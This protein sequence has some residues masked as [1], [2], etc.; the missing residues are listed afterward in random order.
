MKVN[1]GMVSFKA[2]V[3]KVIAK[4]IV[5]DIDSNRYAYDEEL[6]CMA[7]QILLSLQYAIDARNI[8]V[9]MRFLELR[10]KMMEE[11]GS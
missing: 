11:K 9:N 7:Q 10:N 4:G 1:A 6:Y 2:G 5:D 8:S 3:I